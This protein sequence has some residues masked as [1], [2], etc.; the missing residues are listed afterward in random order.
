MKY[1]KI[2]GIEK[3]VSMI[4]L[5][6]MRI[7]RLSVDALEKL[8]EVALSLG[9][10]FFDH[11]DIYGGGQSEIIFGEVLKRNP[12]WREKMI[13][14]SKC[15]IRNGYYDLSK[16]H[17]IS[18]VEASLKH[19]QTD[20]LDVLLLHRPDALMDPAEIGEAFE[21]L[22]KRGI[23]KAFGVS[24][25]TP[26]QIRLIQKHS[27]FP[28]LFNQLQFNVVHS[29]MIDS[30]IYANMKDASAID[31]DGG[32][33]DYC[34]VNDITIQCWSILQASWTEGSY[35]DHPNY[36]ALN[37]LLKS[38]GEKY[39]VSPSAIATAWILRHPAGMQ[40]I[41]GTT[42][43][44]NLRKIAQATTITLSRQDWYALYKSVGRQ[45]P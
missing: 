9:I 25:M 24:N 13:I 7:D 34:R 33:L 31:Y 11:A 28:M 4:A 5:G 2:K 43:P 18:S 35:L 40:A 19:L 20:Y 32:V 39:N 36:E 29:G 12:Q 23:V 45:L 37:L 10:N 15:G 22:Y 38:L 30:G 42:T 21:S 41:A 3:D 44:E 17:I 1:K 14:Q 8:V 26:G 6:C 27:E 16:A